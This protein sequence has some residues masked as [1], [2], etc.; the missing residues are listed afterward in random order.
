MKKALLAVAALCCLGSAA[1][2]GPNAGGTL[3][4]AA[5]VG[6]VYT[7]DH[8]GY[9]GATGLTDCNAA[10][11]RHDGSAPVV[12]NF[13]AAFPGASRLA[14]ITFGMQYTAG[15]SLIEWAH[16]GEFELAN[17]AWPASGEGTAVTFSPPRTDQ[18]V[19]VY[20]LAAYSYYSDPDVLS[21]I[22]H[23]GQGGNFGDDS[24]PSIIDPI[25]G[26]GALGFDTDGSVACP[27]PGDIPGAC[28]FEDGTCQVL[29]ESECADAGGVFQGP[30]VPCLDDTCPQPATGACC[31][32]TPV[33]R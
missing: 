25:A 5:A 14:G 7:T 8:T 16:C 10:V 3:I 17:P 6:T 9:C 29:L 11:T 2:A 28:C 12:F 18:L 30:E 13:I 15:V 33:R 22:P 19:P 23:P 27:P 21:L 32:D 26:Y 31:I 4:V 24:I 1:L 20:W